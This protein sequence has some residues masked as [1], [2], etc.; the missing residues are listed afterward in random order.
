MNCMIKSINHNHKFKVACVRIII[1][2]FKASLY[3]KKFSKKK[4]FNIFFM[5]NN[6]GF[7]GFLIK[8]TIQ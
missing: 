6:E 8:K 7:T 3:N 1:I 4:K 2:N 5:T